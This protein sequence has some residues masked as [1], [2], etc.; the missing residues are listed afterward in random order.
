MGGADWCGDPSG[1]DS[2]V[3]PFGKGHGGMVAGSPLPPA[4]N[5]TGGRGRDLS[6]TKGEGKWTKPCA[7]MSLR[8][9][10]CGFPAGPVTFGCSRVEEH[11]ANDAPR[12]PS[13]STVSRHTVTVCVRSGCLL[14]ARLL[15]RTITR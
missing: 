10:A 1:F 14:A 3:E 6:Q 4:M 12:S 9:G 8:H 5:N 2:V 13:A 11:R 7:G 15:Q